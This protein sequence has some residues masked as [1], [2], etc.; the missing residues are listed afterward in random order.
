MS[1]QDAALKLQRDAR[2][3]A[4]AQSRAKTALVKRHPEEYRD[5]YDAE[6]ARLKEENA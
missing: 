4:R 5:L 1:E 3:R 2:A 6:R